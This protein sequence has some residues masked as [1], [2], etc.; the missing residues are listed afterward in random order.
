MPMPLR[1]LWKKSVAKWN[2]IV[3]E[4]GG[5]KDAIRERMQTEIFSKL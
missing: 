1:A 3:E 2:Q 4:T 5:D